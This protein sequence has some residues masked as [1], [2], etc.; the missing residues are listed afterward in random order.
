[1]T[2]IQMTIRSGLASIDFELEGKQKWVDLR[3]PAMLK[4]ME[5]AAKHPPKDSLTP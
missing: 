3:F 2:R 4:A 1:M 5:E